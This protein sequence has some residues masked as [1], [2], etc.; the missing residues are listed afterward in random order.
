MTTKSSF[1]KI[2]QIITKKKYRLLLAS[3]LSS[4]EQRFDKATIENLF[5][6]DAEKR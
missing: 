4:S 1:I 6:T 5:F 2:F 3:L